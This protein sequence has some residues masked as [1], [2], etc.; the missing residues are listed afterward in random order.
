MAN[1]HLQH[2]RN[3]EGNIQAKRMLKGPS[4]N[5]AA[6]ALRMSRTE[7]RKVTGFITDGG[8]PRPPPSQPT[9]SI[10]ITE[11][12]VIVIEA[13][14]DITF[15]CTG[16]SLISSNPIGIEWS[17][18]NGYLP[19]DRAI[20][21]KRGLLIIK[22]AQASDSGNYICTAS[23][24][25]TF[26]TERA[27]LTVGGLN[28]S[29]PVVSV[30]PRVVDVREGE[31]VEFRCEAT[32][33]PT[34]NVQWVRDRSSRL[35]SQSSFASG[36]F[37]IPYASLVDEG[38]YTC[39]ANNSAGDDSETVSLYVRSAPPT[40]PPTT[41]PPTPI[42]RLTV[43]PQDYQGYAGDT[44]RLECIASS[45]RN[46]RLQWSRL[47]GALSPNA[48]DADGVFTIYNAQPGDSG[49][50]TCT[51]VDWTTGVVQQEVRA[52]VN[53]NSPSRPQPT[54]SIEPP[55]Q[56]V[57]QGT[58]AELRCVTNEGPIQWSKAGDTLPAN[59]KIDGN[60]LRIERIQVLDR[61]V[62]VC[63]V[64]GPAGLSRITAIIEVERREV[65]AIE[66]FPKS[67]QTVTEGG[68][69]LFQCRVLQ[70]IPEPSLHW[71]RVDGTPLSRHVE[72]LP[73]GVLRFNSVAR[74]DE[75]QYLCTADNSQGSATTVAVLEVQSLP[76]ITITPVGQ[77]IKISLGQV[78]RLDCQAYGYPQP[79]VVWSKHQPGYSFYEPKSIT[80]ESPQ[81]AVYEI[82]GATHDDE[83]SYTCSARNA[84]GQVEERIQLIVSDEQTTNGPSSGRGDIP[85]GS[86]SGGVYILPDE[87]FTVPLGGH[88]T[89]RCV[90]QGKRS[91]SS[92]V[93]DNVIA[94]SRHPFALLYFRILPL[95]FSKHKNSTKTN[96]TKQKLNSLL[97]K[98]TKLVIILDQT[99]PPKMRVPPAE[100]ASEARADVNER[101]TSLEI[102]SI[103][104]YNSR[105][106]DQKYKLN[107]NGKAIMYRAKNL[108]NHV[109]PRGLP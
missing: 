36:V 81:G 80:E 7:I 108:N 23:D 29:R 52:R 58:T 82:R 92:G 77:S 34:P 1:K 85:S 12:T 96:I 73:T 79:I 69:A 13:G 38:L 41:A 87:D 39:T 100:G 53:V 107:C 99:P 18:E 17:K 15:R 56:T 59:A 97:K 70:G 84:A 60:I 9:I 91:K 75:G 27:T 71:S 24:G 40:A 5:I 48:R 103:S 49:Y 50:Y 78:V 19:I 20:D 26:V 51:A 21:D 101:K 89:I 30:S 65:P 76:K 8:S 104:K 4:R 102:V 83:G 61:G 86:S 95:H 6:D 2:W 72:Q 32:G 67:S 62:Y 43:Q 46:I 35:P 31:P 66:L 64:E 42:V 68:S 25:Y 3:T 105:G 47:D 106:A 93:V 14:K 10:S 44:V 74:S 63:Q 57:P 54:I 16:R 22:D 33:V 11:P 37:R 98:K 94:E 109:M 90:A 55:R 88:V 45:P 28:I